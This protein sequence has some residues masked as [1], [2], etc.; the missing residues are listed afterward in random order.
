MFRIATLMLGSVLLTGVAM[1]EP[2]SNV[3]WTPEVRNLV[4][5]ASPKVGRATAINEPEDVNSCADCHGEMGDDPSKS[6][7]PMISGQTATYI[8]KQLRDYKDGKRKHKKM[9]EAA[10]LLTEWQM[11]ELG[12][13]YAQQP[14]PKPELDEDE[15][16]TPEAVNLVFFGDK[17]RLIQPCASCHGQQGEGAAQNVPVLVGQDVKYFVDTMK[18][19]AKGK[20]SNDIYSRMR[21]IAEKLSRDEIKQ[22]AIYYARLGQD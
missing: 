8:Y 12:A 2:S 1:A 15:T 20:R 10:E 7:T 3:A 9:Q 5:E 21:I 16:V 19:Y 17:T 4:L 14:L 13:W 22:L 11:A 6:K 18:K